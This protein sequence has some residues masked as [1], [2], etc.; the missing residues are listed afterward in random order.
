M[1]TLYDVQF[2]WGGASWF[3]MSGWCLLLRLG[4]RT[5][6]VWPWVLFNRV[7]AEDERWWGIGLLKINRRALFYVG[8]SGVSVAFIGC[9]N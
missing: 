8:H 3:N 2:K 5:I 9:T 7:M 1:I 6:F 4:T